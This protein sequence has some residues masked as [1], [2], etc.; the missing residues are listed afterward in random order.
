MKNLTIKE[1]RK[2]A[3]K[4]GKKEIKDISKIEIIELCKIIDEMENRLMEA[5][6]IQEVF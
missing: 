3:N 4:I 1:L 5:N 6:K 2:K